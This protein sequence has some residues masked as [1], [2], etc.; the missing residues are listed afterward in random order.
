MQLAWSWPGAALVAALLVPT[1]IWARSGPVPPDLAPRW[2]AGIEGVSRVLFLLAA[3]LTGGSATWSGWTTGVLLAMAGYWACWLRFARGPRTVAELYRPA[4]GIPVPMAVLP[5][6]AGLLLAGH[7]R[8]WPLLAASVVF[9]VAHVAVA[10][11][12][13]AATRGSR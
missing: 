8:S 12:H 7:G 2:L 9:G 1:L 13:A 10:L 11:L 5:P 6:V 3:I 4:L